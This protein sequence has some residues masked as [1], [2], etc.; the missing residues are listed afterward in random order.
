M[1]SAAVRA[2]WDEPVDGVACGEADAGAGGFAGVE[3]VVERTTPKAERAVIASQAL[4]RGPS[5][6]PV[7]G[8]TRA[9]A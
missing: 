4:G 6:V 9:T 2:G 1:F 3:L 5:F 8:V 7:R